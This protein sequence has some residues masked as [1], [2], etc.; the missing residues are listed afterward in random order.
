[1]IYLQLFLSYLKIACEK[2]PEALEYTIGQFIPEEVE[3][4]DFYNYVVNHSDWFMRFNSDGAS[5]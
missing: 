1:M 5:C 4:K 2:S 3:A